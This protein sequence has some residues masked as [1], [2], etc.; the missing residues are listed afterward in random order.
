MELLNNK[1]FLRLAFHNSGNAIFV[2]DEF[3]TVV[4]LNNDATQLT[5]IGW[6]FIENS[7]LDI[8]LP[9][10]REDTESKLKKAFREDE[11]EPIEIYID[12]NGSTKLF[13]AKCV[14]FDDGT[15]TGDPADVKKY[16]QEKYLML[17]CTDV[18]DY[19]LA[20]QNEMIERYKFEGLFNNPGVGVAITDYETSHYIHANEA[21]CHMLGYPF[22]ELLSLTPYDVTHD[23]EKDTIDF[24]K[25]RL[26]GDYEY[27]QLEKRYN[28]KDGGILWGY[29][30]V[31]LIESDEGDPLYYMTT[32][33]DITQ[34][35]LDEDKLRDH[36]KKYHTLFTKS[37]N[38][39]VY[40]KLIYDKR[41]NAKD[42]LILDANHAYEMATGFKRMDIIGKPMM[43]MSKDHFK[44]S[45]DENNN[46]I[47]RLDRILR[48]G[49][50][51]LYRNQ[52]SR[53][54]NKPIDVHY[55]ILDK[56]QNI[57][58]VVFGDGMTDDVT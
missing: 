15:Y 35:K 41:G 14:M 36:E 40:K 31:R 6:K 26:E 52:P 30:V 16:Y 9:T 39:I 7:F 43:K 38:A 3:L 48:E 10:T 18:T 1:D 32:V 49:R 53:T 23:D 57:I 20:E 27:V 8:I 5:G 44:V 47:E 42:Y 17:I 45:D 58:A 25:N 11:C 46:R 54:L 33:Q 51:V 56:D 2:I 55:Y 28:K 22:E 50:D 19:R 37:F 13:E 4:E 29:I 34:K 12:T 24:V 21:F